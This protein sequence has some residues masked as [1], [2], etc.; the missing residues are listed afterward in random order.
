MYVLIILQIKKLRR[1]FHP[2][3]VRAFRR[4]SRHP[5]IL[6]GDEAETEPGLADMADPPAGYDAARFSASVT[7]N[8]E[9]AEKI[10]GTVPELDGQPLGW[11]N[12]RDDQIA[13][14]CTAPS[15]AEVVIGRYGS[16]VPQEALMQGIIWIQAD[17]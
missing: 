14:G 9:A 8:D 11:I 4:F 3:G 12:N 13:E 2:A 17:G 15:S 6:P 16:P 1:D 10:I 5:H 7:L